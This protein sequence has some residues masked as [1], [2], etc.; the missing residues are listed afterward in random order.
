QDVLIH[1]GASGVSTAAIQ[2]ARKFGA[3]RIFTTASS[4]E[5]LEYCRQLGATHLINY[6]TEDFAEFIHDI[7]DGHGV[8]III[9]YIGVDYWKANMDS[10][11]VDG[12]MVVLAF[13]S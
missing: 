12:H 2:I 6:K 5:K 10:L 11:A 9:D 7:T 3:R 4:N 8:D 1:A 13:M